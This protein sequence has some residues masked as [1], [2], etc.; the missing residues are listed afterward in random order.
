M[1]LYQKVERDKLNFEMLSFR[2]LQDPKL[3]VQQVVAY[4]NPIP[5]RLI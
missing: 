5:K 1:A 4:M 2:W 3:E